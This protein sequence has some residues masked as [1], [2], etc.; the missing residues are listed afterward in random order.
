MA[1]FKMI[2]NRL[3]GPIGSAIHALIANLGRIL[4]MRYLEK[5]SDMSVNSEKRLKRSD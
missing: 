2:H 1:S 3:L 4:A 5:A